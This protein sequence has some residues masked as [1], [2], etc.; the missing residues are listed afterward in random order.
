MSG[1][2]LDLEREEPTRARPGALAR[3][4]RRA[5]RAKLSALRE[6]RLVVE[7]GGRSESYG[8]PDSPLRAAIRVRDPAFWSALARRGSLGA[9]ESY[10]DGCWSSDDLAAV[11]RVAARNR[12]FLEGLERGPS[13]LAAPA[14]RLL[15]ALRR[16]TRR[17]AR[18]NIAAHYDLGNEFFS[19]FLDP[20]LTYSCAVFEREGMSLEEAQSAKYERL[21]RKLGL[22]PQHRVLEIG[23]GW[24]SFAIHAAGRHGCRVTTAT[25]SREQ[26]ELARQRVAAAGLAERV[27][28]AFCDYRDLQGTFDRLVSIEMIEAVGADHLDDFFGACGRRLAPDGLFALQAITTP[29]QNYERSVRSVDFVKRYVFPG[30]QLPSLGAMLDA[31]RRTSDLRLVHLEDLTPHYVE[32][33][34]RWHRRLRESWGRLREIGYAERFLRLWEYYLAYCQGGF[35]ERVNGVAQLVF[36]RSQAPP[37]GT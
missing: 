1:S 12:V 26:L 3:L 35:A 32:T 23:G 7:E 25:I 19:L 9:A 6:G 27:E 2:L 21:C 30:G 36:A 24:G 17:G 16:N 31:V 34:S 33:L 18:R 29:D 20:S 5:V 13:R 15:H 11:I 28:V 22:R 37:A 14:Q 4:A 10:M 8:E